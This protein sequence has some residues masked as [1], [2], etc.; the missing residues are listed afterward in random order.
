MGYWVYILRCR[1]DT[2]YT[3]VTTDLSRRVA[4]HNAGTGARYTRG[5]GPVTLVYQEAQPDR[6]RA[7]RR[8]WEIKQLSREEKLRLFSP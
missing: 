7:Q 6:T 4:Q 1:D 3:G 8:E 2:L 5:R